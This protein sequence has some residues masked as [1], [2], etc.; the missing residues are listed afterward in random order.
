MLARRDVD[1]G[2]VD[3]VGGLG[4]AGVGAVD[5]LAV[6]VGRD[7]YTYREIP[8]LSDLPEMRRSQASAHSR[9]TSMAYLHTY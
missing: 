9:T 8:C 2:A 6:I 5:L 1:A 4:H 3:A 7:N